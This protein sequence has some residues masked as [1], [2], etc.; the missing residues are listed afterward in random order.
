MSGDLAYDPRKARSMLGYAPTQGLA[1]T[2]GRTVAWF[3]EEG[4]LPP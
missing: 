1:E 3:R 2:V 4:L